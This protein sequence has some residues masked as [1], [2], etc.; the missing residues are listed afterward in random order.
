MGRDDNHNV[1]IPED[2]AVASRNH[3]RLDMVI[4]S[5][6]RTLYQI[7]DLSSN[8]TFVNGKKIIRNQPHTLETQDIIQIGNQQWRFQSPK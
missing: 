8:G 6:G 7:T 5:Q 3:A 4:N 2:N 1:V